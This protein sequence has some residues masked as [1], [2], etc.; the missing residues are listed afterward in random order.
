M[1]SLQHHLCKPAGSRQDEAKQLIHGQLRD[2]FIRRNL[3]SCTPLTT[4][5]PFSHMFE[6]LFNQRLV[7]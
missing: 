4:F 1:F 3:I 7:E 5:F 2:N 6:E